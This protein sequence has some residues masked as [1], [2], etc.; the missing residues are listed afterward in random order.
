MKSEEWEI[1]QFEHWCWILETNIPPRNPI[2]SGDK[3]KS[4]N[5]NMK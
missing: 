5:E 3:M 4:V 2:N 1:F